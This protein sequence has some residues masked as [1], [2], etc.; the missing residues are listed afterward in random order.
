[1]LLAMLLQVLLVL[2]MVLLRVGYGLSLPY[3]SRAM[4][5]QPSA[6]PPP[7]TRWGAPSPMTLLISAPP[8]CP[9]IGCLAHHSRFPPLD[10]QDQLCSNTCHRR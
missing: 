9:R 8:T 3:T 7:G 10:S 2:V 4:P 5:R 6:C 1:M